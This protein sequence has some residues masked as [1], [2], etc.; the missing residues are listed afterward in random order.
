[1]ISPETFEIFLT[2]PPGLESVLVAELREK[3]FANPQITTGGV[4]IDGSWPDVWR[5]NFEIRGASRILARVGQF[6]VVHLAQLDKKARAIAWGD[7]L[8]KD[9]SVKVE[10]SARRSKLYH[11]GAIAQRIETAISEEFGAAISKDA[12]IR[13]LARIDDNICTISVDTSGELLHRRGFKED[14][15]KAPMRETLA[16]LFLRQCGYS[17]E[18]PVYD[19]MCGSGTF[20]IE[21]AEIAARLNP[22]RERDFA[23]EHL[24][25]FDPAAWAAMR[26]ESEANSPNFRFY[27]SDKDVGAIRASAANAERAG[28]AEITSF[29]KKSAAEIEPPDG[30]PGLVIVNPPYGARIGNLKAL[31]GVYHELG[32]SLRAQ[33]SGWR[34]GL[35]TSEDKLARAT[36]LP[37]GKP[38]R[39]I[40]HGGI[41]IRLYQAKIATSAGNN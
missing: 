40:D 20:V 12:S 2:V 32:Q 8:R 24:A 16:A 17:G 9:V 38:S 26:A 21:A 3:R 39:S 6:R 36:R 11:A 4:T 31:Y 34:V 15:A 18:E 35:L 37:F 28:V 22:G 30:S 13:V 1:M 19:P 29:E 10:A 5:A 25:G 7:V 27:G 33:F 23:F 14:V 41:K